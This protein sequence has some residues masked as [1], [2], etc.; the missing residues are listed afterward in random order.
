LKDAAEGKLGRVTT[1]LIIIW[2]N[3]ILATKTYD[4]FPTDI[5]ARGMDLGGTLFLLIDNFSLDRKCC[6]YVFDV[7]RDACCVDRI[8]TY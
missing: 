8:G 4:H 7:S 6:R 2:V 1:T 3:T 5:Y